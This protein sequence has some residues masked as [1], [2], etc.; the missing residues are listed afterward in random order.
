M[1]VLVDTN[2]LISA[3]LSSNGTP[4]DCGRIYSYVEGCKLYF[5]IPLC[6]HLF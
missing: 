1:R 3:A 4:Y 6:S 5:V 2:I